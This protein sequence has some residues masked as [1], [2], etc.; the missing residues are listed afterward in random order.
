M[1]GGIFQI[2]RDGDEVRKTWAEYFEQVLK[3]KDIREAN[4]SVVGDIRMPVLGDFNKK[5]KK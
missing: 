1:K 2:N 4:I 3:V 5:G